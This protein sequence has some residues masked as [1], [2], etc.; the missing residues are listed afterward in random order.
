MTTIEI[1]GLPVAEQLM[2]MEKLWAALRAQA[3]SGVVPAW[4]KDI[5]AERQRRLDSGRQRIRLA[6]GRCQRAYPRPDQRNHAMSVAATPKQDALDAITRLPGNAD[7]AK[8]SAYVAAGYHSSILPGAE[9]S[10]AVAVA[11]GL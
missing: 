8:H 11:E 5:L 9:G 3:D 4:H 2:P 6:V 10:A 1:V 7:V